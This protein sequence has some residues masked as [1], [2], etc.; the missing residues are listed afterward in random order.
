M[1]AERSAD[2]Q[3]S[4]QPAPLICANRY[5]DFTFAITY[6]AFIVARLQTQATF[7]PVS[8]CP[9]PVR[10]IEAASAPPEMA[11]AEFEKLLPARKL[12]AALV[13]RIG[14]D[15]TTDG[16]ERRAVPYRR[17]KV[18]PAALEKAAG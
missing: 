11:V 3:I 12:P 16:A 18:E 10:S 14:K 7:L 4:L 2:G 8:T 17:M 6:G 5:T 15:E 1:G 13:V 9:T